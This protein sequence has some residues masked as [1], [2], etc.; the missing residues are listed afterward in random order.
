MEKAKVRFEVAYV[1]GQLF[2]YNGYSLKEVLIDVLK[3]CGESKTYN[4][5]RVLKND[6]LLEMVKSNCSQVYQIVKERITEGEFEPYEGRFT[7]LL[8]R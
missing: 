7:Y 4:M 2:N 1:D 3:R 5:L 6:E 8:S